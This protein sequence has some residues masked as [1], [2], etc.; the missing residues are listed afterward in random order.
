MSGEWKCVK[1]KS[2]PDHFIP[3]KFL[4]K[5]I[6]R[7]RNWSAFCIMFRACSQCLYTMTCSRWLRHEYDDFPKWPI[8]R[9]FKKTCFSMRRPWF[10]KIHWFSIENCSEVHRSIIFH[11]FLGKS[12]FCYCSSESQIHCFSI[13]NCSELYRNNRFHL[14][15]ETLNFCVTV[16]T[17]PKYIGF[18][19]KIVRNCTEITYFI[20]SWK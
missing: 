16:Q 12:F 1:L 9:T 8:L 19:L 4:L 10:Y 7:Y 20:Y 11:L 18:L 14:F 5:P 17:N 13:E 15:L 2:S 6:R 3:D